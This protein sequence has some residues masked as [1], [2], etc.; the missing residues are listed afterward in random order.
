MLPGAK[1]VETGEDMVRAFRFPG[2]EPREVL[3]F[4]A[5]AVAFALLVYLASRLERLWR[6]APPPIV[7][8][9]TG[10]RRS[11]LRVAF[12]LEAQVLPNHAPLPFMGMIVDLSA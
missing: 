2:S 11:D 9:N 4:L 5:G 1:T 10:Q 6:K 3:W 7:P 8:P 12:Q